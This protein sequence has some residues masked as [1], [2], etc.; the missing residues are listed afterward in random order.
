MFYSIVT[1]LLE[2][3][4]P[5]FRLVLSNREF[6][7]NLVEHP[8]SF[9]A[10]FATFEACALPVNPSAQLWTNVTAWHIACNS[11]RDTDGSVSGGIQD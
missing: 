6:K 11:A 7:T 9:R 3:R 5:L 4:I 8:L 1:Q 2:L 10:H